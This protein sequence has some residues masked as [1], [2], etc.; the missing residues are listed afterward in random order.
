MIK[1]QMK[2]YIKVMIKQQT[3]AHVKVINFHNTSINYLIFSSRWSNSK[4][5]SLRQSD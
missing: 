5:E 1:Q 4:L 3:K 2:V